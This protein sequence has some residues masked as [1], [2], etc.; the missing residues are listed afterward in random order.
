VEKPPLIAHDVKIK[1]NGETEGFKLAKKSGIKQWSIEDTALLPPSL[2][3]GAASYS[4]YSP[5]AKIF[6]EETD[7]RKGFQDTIWREYSRYATSSCDSRFKNRIMLPPEQ[8]TA[9][10]AAT[11]TDNTRAIADGGMEAWIDANNLTHWTKDGHGTVSQG[12][13]AGDKHAGTYSVHIDG[14][15]GYPTDV[16]QDLPF[17]TADRG[18]SVTV[19]FW[20]KT[21]AITDLAY[22]QVDDGVDTTETSVTASSTLVSHT[23]THTLNA[24]AT[25]LRVLFHARDS[26]GDGD[27]Y[28]D[29]VSI[30]RATANLG[31]TTDLMDFGSDIVYGSG[32]TLCKIDSGSAAIVIDFGAII[33]SLC[34]FEDRLFIA[35]G[36]SNAYWYTS[37]L[38]TFTKS[39]FTGSE[40]SDSETT[41]TA[42]YSDS[43]TSV[44]VVDYKVFSADDVYARWE[45]E[46]IQLSDRS[47]SPMTVIR[48]SLGTSGRAHAS[49]TTIT[50]LSAVAGAQFMT[51]V[52]GN[53]QIND[54]DN[55]IRISDDP[56][57]NGTPFST[58]YTMPNSDYAITGLPPDS[59]D[60]IIYV[61]KQDQ[62]YY[63]SGADVLPLLPELASE[64]STTN[65][66]DIYP[67]KGR[68]YIPSGVNSL[69]EYD[70][71]T[72]T[73]ISI[74]KEAFGDTDFD[75]K[76]LCTAW[77]SEYLI[78][79]LENGATCE[80]L[81][82]SWRTLG[83]ATEWW[84]HPLYSI[85]S[86][87]YTTALI[88]SVDGSK[89]LYL[90][91]GT[92]TDGIDLFIVPTS[93]SDVLKESGYEVEASG[94][95]VT[96]WYETDFSANDKMWI[97][98]YVTALNF[99]DISSIRT[100][101]QKKGDSSWTELGY[102]DDDEYTSVAS[103]WT[104]T[105]PDEVTT[106][107]SM[108]V[109]SQRV[110]FKFTLATTESKLSPIIKAYSIECRLVP[111]I[112]GTSIKKKRIRFEVLAGADTANRTGLVENKR[113]PQ[114]VARLEELS[115][116]TSVLKVT[117]PDEVER[118][119]LFEP[120]G[121]AIS[122]YIDDK[123]GASEIGEIIVSCSLREV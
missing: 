106:I 60:G 33:T 79:V 51:S 2:L 84:W 27:A 100:Y 45:D 82:G 91:T 111:S 72:V 52:D 4:N 39:S 92:S 67:W 75:G 61:R 119:A 24:S 88:S 17:T 108:N 83:G 53:F 122:P 76:V 62:V 54:S 68:L 42:A 38:T 96:P 40:T 48:A 118:S 101:Y 23:I 6:I 36:S 64:V 20:G 5:E 104:F 123:K 22:G 49:G 43:A 63:L 66:Y 10:A 46:V 120:D 78:T 26:A 47:A 18:A 110:R 44:A 28:I 73:D 114:T 105:Y 58:V 55:T 69:Y 117:L 15:S 32:C 13:A 35:L 74:V 81:A 86:N 30:T 11:G 1:V 9:I 37:D 59:G 16:Y 80:I 94:D 98:F 19:T 102:C 41:T 116:S 89:R 34:N 93:Y 8:Q 12:T 70:A 85:T 56:I 90:G 29:D 7:W 50:E 71:G 31:A 25:Q 121:F 21:Q 107:F 57:N 97:N 3:M 112:A 77:D 103:P 109:V 113:I 14:G 87:D 95:I 99:R 65:S 115:K